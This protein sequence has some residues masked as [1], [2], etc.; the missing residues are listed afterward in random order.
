VASLNS[1]SVAKRAPLPPTSEQLPVDLAVGGEHDEDEAGLALDEHRLRTG[2]QLRASG[3]SGVGARRHGVVVREPEVDA[4]GTQ[5]A[6]EP[7]VYAGRT[8]W[9]S[10][11]RSIRTHIGSRLSHT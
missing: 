10:H 8:R 11:R 9:S 2:T 6:D 7:L 5:H 3:R 1:S 4:L